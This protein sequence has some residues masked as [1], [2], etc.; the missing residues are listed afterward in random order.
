M[1]FFCTERCGGVGCQRLRIS[2]RTIRKAPEAGIGMGHWMNL[3]QPDQ[4]A[5]PG[6]A[7]A[8]FDKLR[9][10]GNCTLAVGFGQAVDARAAA[11]QRLDKEVLRRGRKQK[12]LHLGDGPFKDEPR[13]QQT[14]GLRAAGSGNRLVDAQVDLLQAGH[15]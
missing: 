11:G 2:G 15:E 8:L 5:L 4:Q 3:V 12:G 1:D 7:N 6:G 13:R 9:G 10:V 14:P